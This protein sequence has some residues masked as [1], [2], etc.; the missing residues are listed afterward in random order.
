MQLEKYLPFL[1]LCMCFNSLITMRRGVQCISANPVRRQWRVVI[2]HYKLYLSVGTQFSQ[3]NMAIQSIKTNQQ[4][5]WKWNTCIS[6]FRET[7]LRLTMCHNIISMNR[8]IFL[9][10]SLVN[11]TSIFGFVFKNIS[12]V[13][14]ILNLPLKILILRI[15]IS[16]I[17][18]TLYCAQH[19]E[20]SL[21]KD[22]MKNE[23]CR[24][25]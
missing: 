21:K 12:H 24:H 4:D 13:G 11:K 22:L 16:K 14:L 1:F 25:W 3:E 23:H 17:I 2:I 15:L 18:F 7:L 8:K 9:L 5:I 19:Q 10:H 20:S 6:T